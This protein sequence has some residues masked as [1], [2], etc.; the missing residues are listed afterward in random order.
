MMGRNDTIQLDSV[1][2]KAMPFVC[3]CLLWANT[4]AFGQCWVMWTTVSG[5]T[6]VWIKH[7]TPRE[8]E[9]NEWQI[10]TAFTRD[11]FSHRPLALTTEAVK[12]SRR[13]DTDW[14]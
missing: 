2:V 1:C 13:H 8:E 11:C 7:L 4:V 3:A 5:S 12:L 9:L 14:R 10:V 6:R